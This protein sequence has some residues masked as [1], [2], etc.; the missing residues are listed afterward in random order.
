MMQSRGIMLDTHRVARLLGHEPRTVRRLAELGILPG[1]KL[2]SV[3]GPW[4]FWS[5]DI[6]SFVAGRLAE[7]GLP[8]LPLQLVVPPSTL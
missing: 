8:P 1:F 5:D 6:N 2:G 7:Q 3:N 4:R